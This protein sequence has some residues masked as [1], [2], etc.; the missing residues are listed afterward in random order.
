MNQE[1]LIGA[2]HVDGKFLELHH[3]LIAADIEAAANHRVWIHVIHRAPHRKAADLAGGKSRQEILAF[4]RIGQE[5]F[6]AG[7]VELELHV[8]GRGFG[9][10]M[11]DPGT[12]CQKERCDQIKDSMVHSGPGM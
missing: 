6:E 10:L 4:L 2:L 1:R 9:D 11:L 5:D 3:F 7:L 8:T 12:A